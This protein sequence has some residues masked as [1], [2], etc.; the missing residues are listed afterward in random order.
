MQAFLIALFFLPNYLILFPFS[1]SENLLFLIIVRV[2]LISFF[3]S[4]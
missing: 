4:V 3:V 2:E 1:S